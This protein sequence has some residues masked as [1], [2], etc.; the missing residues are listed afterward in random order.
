MDNIQIRPVTAE[1]RIL[2]G[3]FLTEQ[4]DSVQI[5]ARGR[6]SRADE[7]PGFLALQG[8]RFLGLITYRIENY[9]CEIVTMN[10][11]IEGLGVGTELLKMAIQAAVEKTCKRVWAIVT[12]DNLN[13]LRC[14]QTRGFRLAELYRN[15]VNMAREEHPEIPTHGFDSIPIL[16]EIEVEMRLD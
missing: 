14:F 1:D 9:E 3:N 4:S 7:L 6:T 5:I 8:E 12:N 11:S 13:A 16:D 10:S 15:A 2:I